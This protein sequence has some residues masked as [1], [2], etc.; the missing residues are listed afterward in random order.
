MLKHAEKTFNKID[1]SKKKYLEPS[2][3]EKYFGVYSAT[4]TKIV[5]REMDSNK[6]GKVSKSEWMGYWEMVRR[7]GHRIS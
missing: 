2:D 3:L 7:A 4:A 1:K 5:M 6:D